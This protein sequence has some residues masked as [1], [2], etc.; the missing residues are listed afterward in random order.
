MQMV[1]SASAAPAVAESH[2]AES[3]GLPLGSQSCY[4]SHSPPANR[5][6][7]RGSGTILFPSRMGNPVGA[8]RCFWSATGMASHYA[9]AF[10]FRLLQ[11]MCCSSSSTWNKAHGGPSKWD[12]GASTAPSRSVH[13]YWLL[14]QSSVF[15]V[16]THLWKVNCDRSA[17]QNWAWGNQTKYCLLLQVVYRYVYIYTHIYCWCVATVDEAISDVAVKLHRVVNQWLYFIVFDIAFYRL[18][19]FTFIRSRKLTDIVDNSVMPA[20]KWL[21]LNFWT[22]LAWKGNVTCSNAALYVLLR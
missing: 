16:F 15:S 21:M 18:K 8:S 3:K 13:G 14:V 17:L 9:S 22:G 5:N 4:A 7:G 2:F 19:K 1:K 11:T 6:Q 12:A 20:W 10:P